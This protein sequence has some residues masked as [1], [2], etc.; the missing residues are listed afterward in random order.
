M[1]HNTLN[2]R[3]FFISLENPEAKN[4]TT[5]VSTLAIGTT[6]PHPSGKATHRKSI[7]ISIGVQRNPHLTDPKE[8]LIFFA[9]SSK[10]KKH[11]NK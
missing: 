5:G 2:Y 9:N 4:H 1:A 8:N 10:N 3:H 7:S 6:G 11:R